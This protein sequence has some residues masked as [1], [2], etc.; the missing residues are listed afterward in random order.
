[1]TL[2]AVVLGV[3]SMVPATGHATGRTDGARR[4]ATVVAHSRVAP[5]RNVPVPTR[6]AG[7]NEALDAL[8]I[9]KLPATAT[10]T[11][12]ATT[13][14]TTTRRSGGDGAAPE[15]RAPVAAPAQPAPTA[16]ADAVHAHAAVEAPGRLLPV[17]ALGLAVAGA[18][19]ALFGFRAIAS[20]AGRQDPVG[21]STR[22]SP[23]SPGRVNGFRI[24]SAKRSATAAV[25]K[26]RLLHYRTAPQ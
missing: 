12:T 5:P 16:T 24:G 11:A 18:L 17:F 13:T 15:H 7:C 9:C 21:R 14:T 25:A 26:E 8:A 23:G 22:R 3:M 19:L 20:A 4:E 2:G 1:M 10:A 6:S